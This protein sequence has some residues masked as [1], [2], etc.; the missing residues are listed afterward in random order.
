MDRKDWKDREGLEGLE[1]WKDWKGCGGGVR[2]V[3]VRVRMRVRVDWG[4]ERGGREEERKEVDV[5]RGKDRRRDV[6]GGERVR[7]GGRERKEG[8]RGRN[9]SPSTNGLPTQTNTSHQITCNKPRTGEP[10]HK[11]T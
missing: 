7:E 3:G 5:R 8:G 9:N 10:A 6:E 1:G 4:G 2:G 11:S